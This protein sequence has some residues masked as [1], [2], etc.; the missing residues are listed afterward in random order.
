MR[1]E[2]FQG[3]GEVT[4]AAAEHT[5]DSGVLLHKWE[6]RNVPLVDGH[7][8]GMDWVK[9]AGCERHNAG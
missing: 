6:G 5:V 1:E 9:R 8:Y 2:A 7:G 3:D 4:T